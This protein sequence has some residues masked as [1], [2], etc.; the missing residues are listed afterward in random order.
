MIS[1]RCENDWNG[2]EDDNIETLL[3]QYGKN[4]FYMIKKSD[5]S[6]NDIF[7]QTG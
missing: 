5:F 4:C 7:F 6:K 2:K 3:E 1:T